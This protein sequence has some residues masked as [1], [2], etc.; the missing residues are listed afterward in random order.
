VATNLQASVPRGHRHGQTIKDALASKAKN[1]IKIALSQQRTP[2]AICFQSRA[3]AKNAKPTTQ[4]A[5]HKTHNTKHT[6]QHAK[7]KTQ[8]TKH[9][10]QNTKGR[11][12]TI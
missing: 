9:K 4:N 12:Q 1:V 7:H 5:K 10:T 3:L 11:T 2:T 8:N 6:T